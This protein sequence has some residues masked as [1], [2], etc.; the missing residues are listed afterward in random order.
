MSDDK[1][2]LYYLHELPDYK[3]ASNYSDV[4]G[5]IVQDFDNRTIGTVESLLVD[6]NKE[7]VVYLDVEVNESIIEDGYTTY[8]VPAS[9]GIH[10]FINK[11]GDNH[12]IV[13]INMATIDKE[14]KLVRTNELNHKSFSAIRRFSKWSP[15]DQ[16]FELNVKEDYLAQK[17]IVKPTKS[18]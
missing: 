4:R 12:I 17:E 14:N 11:D 10:G 3:V 6:K 9:E 2:N 8:S 1:R 13:P 5:W 18:W 7:L 15:I 16:D